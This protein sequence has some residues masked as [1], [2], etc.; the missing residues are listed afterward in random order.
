MHQ[1]KN[2]LIEIRSWIISSWRCTEWVDWIRE[3]LNWRREGLLT[4]FEKNRWEGEIRIIGT[5]EK[6]RGVRKRIN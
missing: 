4:C 6:I 2:G 3:A 1:I 5:F